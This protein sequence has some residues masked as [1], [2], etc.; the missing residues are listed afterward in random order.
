MHLGTTLR[1]F[2]VLPVLP[3]IVTLGLASACSD[4][5]S[6][7]RDTGQAGDVN[8]DGALPVDALVP[9]TGPGVCTNGD[10]RCD[11]L[12]KIERCEQGAWV[13]FEDCALK[14]L[15]GQSCTCSMTFLYVCTAGGNVCP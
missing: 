3:L 6:P 2:Q 1:V 5:E 13:P 12:F 8:A 15:G 4:D 14:K 7:P 11:G 10:K 9:D